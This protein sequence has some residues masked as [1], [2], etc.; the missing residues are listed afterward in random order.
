MDKT[1][2]GVL[3]LKN[4]QQA[5]VMKQSYCYFP[6]TTCPDV[7][8]STCTALIFQLLQRTLYF[9]RLIGIFN[10]VECPQNKWAPVLGGCYISSKLQSAFPNQ[11]LFFSLLKLMRNKIQQHYGIYLFNWLFASYC[12]I[13]KFVGS[14]V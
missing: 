3:L 12:F 14:P 9:D 8:Y 5:A 1:L 2:Q 13:L 4:N 10:I 11:P 6:I 7:F